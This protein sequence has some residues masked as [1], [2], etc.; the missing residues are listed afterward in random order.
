MILVGRAVCSAVSAIA[1]PAA[2]TYVAEIASSQTRGFLGI[3]YFY[4]FANDDRVMI[5]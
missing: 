4:P 1:V 2:Y 3:R 5:K